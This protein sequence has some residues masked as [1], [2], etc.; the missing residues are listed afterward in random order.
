[1]KSNVFKFHIKLPFKRNEWHAALRY[2]TTIIPL[3]MAVLTLF[4]FL[5]SAL[6]KYN[7]CCLF[8]MLCVVIQTQQIQGENRLLSLLLITINP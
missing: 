6:G 5:H 3:T 1:M 4:L 7:P 8:T 2:N